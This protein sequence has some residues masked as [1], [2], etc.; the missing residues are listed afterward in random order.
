MPRARKIIEAIGRLMRTQADLQVLLML[1]E[2]D[3]LNSDAAQAFKTV[4][5]LRADERK[6]EA[7]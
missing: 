2:A 7:L 6:R 5:Q 4:R 3:S 1:D